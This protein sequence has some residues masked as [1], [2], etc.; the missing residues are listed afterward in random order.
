MNL[1]RSTA[2]LQQNFSNVSRSFPEYS[3]GGLDTEDSGVS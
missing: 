3:K 2:G 1:H